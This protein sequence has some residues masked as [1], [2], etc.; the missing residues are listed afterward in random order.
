ML[1][2]AFPALHNGLCYL[3]TAASALKPRVVADAMHRFD[4]SDY[5]NVH[6]SAYTLGHKAS[7]A[8]DRARETCAAFIGAK[9]ERFV[10]V[11]GATAGINLIAHGF[12][13]PQ[14]SEQDNIVVTVQEHHANWLPWWDVAKTCGANVRVVPVA[15][16]GLI[17]TQDIMSQV[18]GHTKLVA[19][20]HV[21][22]VTGQVQPIKELC[23]ALPK[24]VYCC[25]DGAQAVAHLDVNVT[26]L[27]CDF[28]VASGHKMYG[29]SGIGFVAMSARAF[30]LCQP[31]QTGG[32]MVLSV[33]HGEVMFQEGPVGLEAGTPHITG[34]IGLAAAC[35]W[36]RTVGLDVIRAHEQKLTVMALSALRDSFSHIEIFGHRHGQ[37]LGV[38]SF[39]MPGIHPHDIATL[40]DEHHVAMRAGHHCAM[41]LM[42]HW[43][44]PALTRLSLGVYNE[45]KDII[46]MLSALHKT[47]QLFGEDHGH[48]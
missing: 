8:F 2:E 20:S 29:P 1:R 30:E 24:H 14:L 13:K 42:Q 4:L 47:V 12:L 23:E 19:I 34:V 5:A 35:D 9:P 15:K 6:R 36:L 25:V 17:T 45:E 16:D 38:I 10:W 41:P 18:D 21:S 40:L 7:Q 28:Y 33:G 46:Q 31:Y 44:V 22:N 26:D 32:G 37:Q 27:G 39:A 11:S 43:Q 48:C 3:D